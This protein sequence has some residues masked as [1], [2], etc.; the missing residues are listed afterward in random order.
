MEPY[1]VKPE[2]LKYLYELLVKNVGVARHHIDSYNELLASDLNKIVQE[3]GEINIT[4][5][6]L[7]HRIVFT[8]VS[9][10]QPSV[11]EAS[12][13]QTSIYPIDARLRN[14]TYSAPINLKFSEYKNEKLMQE[15]TIKIGDFPIMVKS[16]ACRL[17]NLSPEELIKVGEDPRDPGGYFIIN[18]SER[19]IVGVEDFATNRIFTERK[20]V[21]SSIIYISRTFSATV[22][23]RTKVEVRFDSQ[24]QLIRVR[25][26]G[27]GEDIPFVILMRALGVSTDK[28]IAYITSPYVEVQENLMKSFD[29]AS[30]FLD[31]E[32]A[33]DYIGGRAAYGQPKEVRIRRAEYLIDKV[34]LPHIGREPTDRI[35]KAYFIGKMAERAI[36]VKLGWRKPD[37]KDHYKNKRLRFAGPLI[38]ELF[39][40]G[41]RRMVRDLKH[42]LQRAD[43]KR[44][45]PRHI[46][47]LV[48]TRLITDL[49]NHAIATGNW[50][51][52]LVGVSQLLDR[53]NYLSTVSH[54][55]RLQS[56]LSRSQSNFEARDLHPTQWGRIDPAESPE[57]SN[58]GL[59]KNLSLLCQVSTT[60][61]PE[62][63]LKILNSLG[64]VPVEKANEEITKSW[65]EIYVN[66]TL[67][68]YHQEGRSIF[69]ELIR[70]RRRGK[71]SDQVNFGFYR[72]NYG[73]ATRKRGK[74]K[75]RKVEVVVNTDAGRVRRPL[76]V[77]EEGQLRLKPEHIDKLKSGE[78]TVDDLVALG[79][80]EYLDAEEEENALIAVNLD[81]ISQHTTH[82]E[83]SP[84]AIFGAI[85]STIPFAEHNQSPRN[86]YEGAMAKQ[87]LGYPTSSLPLNFS[88]TSHYL[89]YP[90]I[91]ITTT[92]TSEIIGLSKN[93]I[94][95]NFIVAVLSHPYNM[96][97]AL[98]LNKASIE[99]GLGRSAT[100]FVYEAEAK[101]YPVGEKDRIQKP[102][103]DVRGYKGE[104]AYVK[105]DEDGIVAPETYVVGNDIII[106]RTSPP[107]FLEERVEVWGQPSYRRDTSVAVKSSHSGYV[108]KI[109]LTEDKEQNKIIKVRIRDTRIPELGDKFATRAGQKGVVGMIV[110]QEDMPFT[111]DGMVPDALINPHAIPSRMTV[112]HF[113]ESLFGIAGALKGRQMFGDSFVHENPEQVYEIL[114]SHGFHPYGD[115]VMIN[116]QTG[117]LLHTKVFI[118]VVYYQRLHHMVKDK[119]HARARGQVTLLTHQ[120]TEG[121][122]RGGGLRFGEMERDCLVGHG[123]ARLLQDRLLEESD[124]TTVYV[125]DNCG[126]LAYYDAKQRKYVCRVCGKNAKISAVTVSYAF[127][128]LLQEIMS[129]GIFPKIR[130]KERV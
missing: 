84:L 120:P 63:V 76:L 110:P 101:L 15:G 33:L 97:D 47:N 5:P 109:L 107:R 88:T 73:G 68:G 112:A 91:P 16:S 106:G 60:S 21:G 11:I 85:S 43:I 66:G 52:R 95:Q 41:F 10:E 113:L 98:V 96:E 45:T 3:V 53:T 35:K 7:K 49:L 99:R 2:D 100:Y 93:P 74:E 125:C 34:L 42:Q 6:D 27:I 28:D 22:G 25:F 79:V 1:S 90:Q 108:D 65:A 111:E 92:T 78:L 83:I 26:P 94:G 115:F 58:C 72:H 82:L 24:K 116:G 123:A 57:G 20:K 130:L 126:S 119:I 8:G 86:T 56:T 121:R 32:S 31:T 39:R 4:L 59:V 87:A 71:I 50:S 89:L 37:D 61:N 105:L 54:L 18:G 124:K 70:L 64:M 75:E 69:K 127:K 77:V 118:G 44:T 19:V 23:Y 62:E 30:S 51:R 122:A 40:Q 9:L 128:L 114:K 80:I 55:R 14:L 103:S 13:A 36:A 38:A 102:E 48:S 29:E 67:V 104:E 81:D 17:N 129:L 12:G 46:G 117:E